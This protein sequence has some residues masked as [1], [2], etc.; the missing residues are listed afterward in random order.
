M[1]KFIQSRNYCF[2][3][4]IFDIDYKILYENNKDI[5]RYICVGNEICP[6]TN[7][8]HKQGWIQFYN[9]KRRGG[10]KKIIGTNKWFESCKGSEYDNNKYCSK[11]KDFIQFGKFITQ[12][13]RTDLEAIKK[14]I[15]NGMNRLEI[16]NNHFETYCKYRNGI[17]DYIKET[18]NKS[19]QKFRKI[20]TEFVYG[21]TGTGKTRYAM[22]HGGF[23]IEGDSLNW[24][25]GYN[26]EKKLIIDEYDNDVKIT[27]LLNIL[28]GYSLRLPIKGG[29]TYAN[30]EKV[31]ITS[32]LNPDQLHCNAKIKHREAL[33]RRI[34]KFTKMC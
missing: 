3:D 23:K 21:S 11:E 31:I 30:W 16:M 20:E 32:N 15:D 17:N 28:D 33:F 1:K 29:F 19:R 26:G 14:N 2:T 4:F 13:A 8:K 9:K 12:G 7:K 27:K 25:D 10:V 5:I 24:F 34:K 6:K 18:E 22:K